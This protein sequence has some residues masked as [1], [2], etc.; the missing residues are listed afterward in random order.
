MVE[1]VSVFCALHKKCSEKKN[2]QNMRPV[3]HS[4]QCIRSIFFIRKCQADTFFIFAFFRLHKML[5][6]LLFTHSFFGL[7][8]N[9][10]LT[11]PSDWFLRFLI[12]I[13]LRLKGPFRCD[14]AVSDRLCQI[15]RMCC[16]R[17]M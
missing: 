16:R 10:G 9:D 14:W 5:I 2:K 3:F 17:Q 4:M 13:I 8:K 12:E 7:Y 15:R 6:Y 1:F 11:T